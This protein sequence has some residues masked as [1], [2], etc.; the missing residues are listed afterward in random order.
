LKKGS[1]KQYNSAKMCPYCKSKPKYDKK[2]RQYICPKCQ[3]K[4]NAD[5]RGRPLGSVASKEM[6]YKRWYAHSMIEPLGKEVGR[7]NVYKYLSKVLGKK[8]GTVH[9]AKM[10]DIQLDI[11]IQILEHATVDKI[12][13]RLGL[14]LKTE[15]SITREEVIKIIDDM[16]EEII[17]AKLSLF[18]ERLKALEFGPA[19]EK[20][21][22]RL[23]LAGLSNRWH[24]GY[25][26]VD[27]QW[28]LFIYNRITKKIFKTVDNKN[29]LIPVMNQCKVPFK[30]WQGQDKPTIKQWIKDYN[31][32]HKK[33]SN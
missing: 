11:L 14:K 5:S 13:E 25:E 26:Q 21:E 24:V 8:T 12:Q 19:L 2:K 9:T 16:C 6:A 17:V 28:N 33:T 27:N 10:S 1:A 29:D 7:N 18:E 20:F 3:A 4:V 30:V 23:H 22:Y 15:N 31:K 32:E